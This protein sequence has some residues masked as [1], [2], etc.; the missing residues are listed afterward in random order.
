M[1]SRVPNPT[2]RTVYL[3]WQDPGSL[4]NPRLYA[5]LTVGL[6]LQDCGP[7]TMVL[8]AL[9]ALAALLG[10]DRSRPLWGWSAMGLFFWF[11]FAPK[12]LEHDYYELLILPVLAAWGALGWRS[13]RTAR[14]TPARLDP[15]DRGGDPGLR[16]RDPFAL[17]H[18]G[19][20]RPGD[21]PPDRGRAIEAALSPDGPGDRPGSTQRMARGPLQRPTGVGR[22]VGRAPGELA[23][24]LRKVPVASGP[25][26]RPSI[27]TRRSRPRSARPTLRCWNRSPSS[28]TAPALGSRA[29]GHVSTISSVWPT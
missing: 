23:G 12:L 28:S 29:S 1:C 7:V 8:I 11:V 25:S 5:R 27:S 19:K 24:D 10:T 6:F 3:F 9:G 14:G 26:T 15:V 18:G 16:H 4:F 21:R 22:A 13:G 17:G 2:S 20:V